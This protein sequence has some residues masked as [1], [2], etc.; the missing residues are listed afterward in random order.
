MIARGR[1]TN[2]GSPH[3]PDS[4]RDPT[5]LSELVARGGEDPRVGN[6]TITAVSPRPIWVV[7]RVFFTP[8]CF[9]KS[10]GAGT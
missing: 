9:E 6:V 2:G 3:T 10:G 5:L 7:A 8:F 4:N 1:V